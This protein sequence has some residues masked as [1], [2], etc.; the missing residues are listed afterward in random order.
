MN[1]SSLISAV[2]LSL[3]V[4]FGISGFAQADD[5]KNADRIILADFSEYP[6]GWKAKGGFSKANKIYQIVSNDKGSYLNANVQAEPVRIFKK[7]SWNSK[8]HP[9][10]EWKW[11]V[12]KWPENKVGQVYFYISLDTDMIG[13]PT[14]VK[15]VWSRNLEKGT[16]NKG[17]FF[18]PTEVVIQSRVADS[19]NWIVQRVNARAD[20]K[21]F[22]GRDPKNDAY[23]IGIL[24]DSGIEVDFAKVIA[25]KE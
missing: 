6:E 19:N 15:Y 7:I 8:K 24:V 17:G 18:S 3:I 13:I 22:L 21:K 4:I 11:R 23:G 1:K 14:I 20:F 16:V 2:F 25:L 10:I 12:K 5:Q 9:V